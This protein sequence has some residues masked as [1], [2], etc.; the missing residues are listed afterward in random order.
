MELAKQRGYKP[1]ADE[2]A[3]YDAAM[4]SGALDG[5]TG[6]ADAQVLE[7]SGIKEVNGKSVPAGGCIGESNRKIDAEAASTETARQ[8]S[9]ETFTRS[10]TDSRVVA[11]FSAWS[12]CMK[13]KGYKYKEPL[14]AS[15]DPQFSSR[16]V[17]PQE[18]ATATADIGCRDKTNVAKVWFDVE[19]EYQKKM[20][21]ERAVQLNQ[22]TEELD[23]T[24]KKAAEILA[25]TR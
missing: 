6:G 7:G 2:Q 24:V 4:N 18:I 12:D 1:A 9:A 14:D 23:S 16:E 20:I 8:I 13:G 19:T 3:A 5:T 15:D 10:K 22:E 21:E 17:T 11:A 25:G